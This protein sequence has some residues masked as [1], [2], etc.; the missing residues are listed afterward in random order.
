MGSGVIKWHVHK[1]YYIIE[2][3][4]CQQAFSKK[5]QKVFSLI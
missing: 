5:L 4:K 3:W 1:T 2:M